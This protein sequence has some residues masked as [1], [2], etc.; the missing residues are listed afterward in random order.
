M[1]VVEPYGVVSVL[2]KLVFVKP[3][4]LVCPYRNVDLIP[5]TSVIL[6]NNF[7]IHRE[8]LAWRYLA[9][10]C[11]P[12]NGAQKCQTDPADFGALVPQDRAS[13]RVRV[14]LVGREKV[15][16]RGTERE[17]LR[18]NLKGDA[19]S[20]ALWVD[21]NDKFKLVR[22]LIADDNTEVVRD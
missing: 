19:F 6:D 9:T 3:L 10:N 7:F 17:L 8:V 14:E 16:V 5:N 22:V 20:W 1:N 12:E 18:L 11:H 15:V 21:E 13:M 4:A 2:M